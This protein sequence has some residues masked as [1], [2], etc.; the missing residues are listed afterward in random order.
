V[1]DRRAEDE[2]EWGGLVGWW[3]EW[4]GRVK[5]ERKGK[6]MR[7]MGVMIRYEER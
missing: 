1:G 3:V 4:G 5:K 7:E 6:E 2:R